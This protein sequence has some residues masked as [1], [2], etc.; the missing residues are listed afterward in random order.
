MDAERSA[1]DVLFDAVRRRREQTFR[2]RMA[3]L[4]WSLRKD[5]GFRFLAE[6]NDPIWD[7]YNKQFEVPVGQGDPVS[8][9]LI[10]LESWCDDQIPRILVQTRRRTWRAALISKVLY[11]VEAVWHGPR[12][13]VGRLFK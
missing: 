3:M 1:A 7:Y 5:A 8:R 2:G 12:T 11:W 4:A 10:A 13:F 6:R 9:H